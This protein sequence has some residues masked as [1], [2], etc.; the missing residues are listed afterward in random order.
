MSGR[1][2]VYISVTKRVDS[3]DKQVWWNC[4]FCFSTVPQL[5][6]N[7]QFLFDA[8]NSVIGCFEDKFNVAMKKNRGLIHGHHHHFASSEKTALKKLTINL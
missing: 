7:V 6:E 1:I 2:D 8:A 4:N 5:R 3:Y